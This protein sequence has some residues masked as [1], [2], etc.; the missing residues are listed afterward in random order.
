MDEPSQ[1][2]QTIDSYP[3]CPDPVFVMGSPRS[4]TTILAWSLAQHSQFWTCEETQILWD[5]LSDGRLLKNYFR[6]THQPDDSWLHNHGISPAEYL[7]HVGLGINALFTGQSKGKRWV[8]HAPSH[9]LF[10][11]ALLD[12]FPGARF[13][14]V[15]RSGQRTVHW[16][17]NYPTKSASWSRDF[18]DACRTWARASAKPC[19]PNRM[20]TMAPSIAMAA[21][22]PAASFCK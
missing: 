21:P 4:G 10:G 19:A 14:H 13:V 5:L 8:D 6:R 9:A 7:R 18:H 16:M 15:L 1:T 12:M 3:I 20:N 2:K 22:S 17:I 11:D